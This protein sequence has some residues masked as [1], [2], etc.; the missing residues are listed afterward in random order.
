MAGEVAGGE[1][2]GQVVSGHRGVGPRLIV[3]EGGQRLV[4]R[5]VEEAA[6]RARSRMP[7]DR[8]DDSA[9]HRRCHGGIITWMNHPGFD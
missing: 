2:L 3:V 6:L 7:F 4:I 8:F 9:I 5:E 1:D